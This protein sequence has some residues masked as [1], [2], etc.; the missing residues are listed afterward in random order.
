MCGSGRTGGAMIGRLRSGEANR[1]SH[2]WTWSCSDRKLSCKVRWHPNITSP[3]ISRCIQDE[4]SGT[5]GC[6][7]NRP[8]QGR[9][10]H[11]DTGAMIGPIQSYSRRMNAATLIV[12]TLSGAI[13]LLGAM[14][15][16]SPSGLIGIGQ[17]LQSP[18]ALY[19]VA[20]IRVVL[21]A[22]LFWIAP[23]SR[24]PRTLRAIGVFVF[25]AG[26]VTPIVGV[27]RA[28]AMLTWWSGQGSVFIRAWACI[29]IAFGIFII[30]AVIPRNR[31]SA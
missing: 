9:S 13:I 7:A 15:L 11:R 27:D 20:F 3:G 31:A 17:S 26:V 14:G 24:L 28:Q 16:V 10:G 8:G 5:G 1:D 23:A 21:G 12:L 18:E 6:G 2:Q 29:A 4:V 19:A 22:L 30:Y 25:A